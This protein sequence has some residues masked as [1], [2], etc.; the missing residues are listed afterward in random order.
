MQILQGNQPEKV[1]S[2]LNERRRDKYK[3]NSFSD[4]RKVG[5]VIE[6]GALRGV[7]SS[8]A[9]AALHQ[10]G[11]GECF[12]AVYGT[13][14]GSLNAAY[15]ASGQITYGTTV[16]YEN[17][18]DPKFLTIFR[19]PNQIDNNWLFDEWIFG[20][21]SLDVKKLRKKNI[22]LLISTTNTNSG[23]LK[24]FSLKDCDDLVLRKALLASCCTPLFTTLQLEICGENYNDGMLKAGIPMQKAV[25]DGCT[26]ITALLT[27]PHE[28][29]K[30]FSLKLAALEY[31]L[32][33]RNFSMDYRVSYFSRASYYNEAISLIYSQQ[34][35]DYATLAIAPDFKDF[36]VM[37]AERN[38]GK[39]K[40][41]AKES[42]YRVAKVFGADKDSVAL[43]GEEE[44]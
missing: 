21:K 36:T 38:P 29:R 2:V 44:Q 23:E 24:Y 4:G 39:L 5:L 16:Y 40:R 11:Y 13:S 37:N 43:F 20:K 34:E 30:K 15:F 28:T 19:W 42:L 27:R 7:I 8:G 12:D 31:M 35:R 26:H 41:A 33:L 32:R 14:S 6:G 17:A 25:E 3:P 9:A 22:D 18:V 1:I 10:L